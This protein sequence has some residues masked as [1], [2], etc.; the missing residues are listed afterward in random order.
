MGYYPIL[1]KLDNKIALVAGGGKVA[2]RKVETLLEFGASVNVVAR[3]LVPELQKLVDDNIIRLVGD[4]FMDRHLDDT[5]V[6]IAATDDTALNHKI[7]ETAQKRGLLV[8]AVDQPADCNFIVPSI[9]KRGELLIAISTSG[10]SPALAKAIREKLEGEFGVEY[11]IFVTLMGHLRK[12][13]L[14][15]GL[16]Q[17][18]NSDI[19]TRIVQ[20][21]ILN[22][23]SHDDWEGVKST[24][25]EIL[26]D[27]INIK[28]ILN[29]L[30]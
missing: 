26:P 4:E 28:G 7:A 22:A 5:E 11:A 13:I 16:S 20:S 3:E 18:E 1:F 21:D 8:N 29:K 17:G 25:S 10:R 23:I 9:I 12:E 24:L 27:N 15:K 6:V 19:F 30:Y 2:R 14:T